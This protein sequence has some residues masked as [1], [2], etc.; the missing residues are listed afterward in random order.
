MRRPTAPVLSPYNI[1]GALAPAVR[2]HFGSVINEPIPEDLSELL[3]ELDEDAEQESGG[4][5]S[6]AKDRSGSH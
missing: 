2:A 6:W 3:R 5:G 4:R 1:P